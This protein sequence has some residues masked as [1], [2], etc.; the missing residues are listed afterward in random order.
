MAVY[1]S[2]IPD[3]NYY[4]AAEHGAPAI[5]YAEL[6][7]A[8][9]TRLDFAQYI[10]IFPFLELSDYYRTDSHWRQENITD[11]AQYLAGQMGATE[12]NWPRIWGDI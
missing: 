11:A 2:V 12:I 7:D 9:R 3:K 6:V 5:N 1:L 10:D 4:M 8:L